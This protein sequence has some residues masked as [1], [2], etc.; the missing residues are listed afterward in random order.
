MKRYLFRII[1]IVLCLCLLCTGAFAQEETADTALEL[2]FPKEALLSSLY[3]ADITAIRQAID[4]KLITCEELTAYYLARIEAYDEDY[5]CF[6]TICDN[7]LEVARERDAQLAEGTAEGMLFGIPVVIKDNMNLEG[8]YTTNGRKKSDSSIAESDA[9][10]VSRLLEEGAVVLA[11]ANMSTDAQDAR[12][13]YSKAAGETKNAYN[14]TLASGGSSGGSA[15]AT[16]LNF[17][18]ASLGTDTNS[19]LR[20]PA[21]LNGCV[22]L[23]P[24]FGLIPMDGIKKL[25][26]SRDMPGAITR[27]VY[28]LAI[29]MDV[30]TNHEYSYT[31]NLNDNALDG[32]RIGV[33]KQLVREEEADEEVL[34]AFERATEE[35]R[36]CGAEVVSVSMSNLFSLAKKTLESNKKELKENLYEE[37]LE[38][39]EEN[40][41]DA[42]VF[43]T[44]SSAPLRSG[45]DEN[46]KYWNAWEQYFLNNCRT[47]GP[48]ASVPEATVIIGYHSLGAGIGM[49]I[50]AARNSEQLLLDIAYTY[51]QRYDHREVPEGAPDSYADYDEGTLPE[52]IDAYLLSLIPPEP[53]YEPEELE[54]P[55][56]NEEP[57]D[58]TENTETQMQPVEDTV[59][60]PEWLCLT[61][62]GAVV[63]IFVFVLARGKR[64]RKSAATKN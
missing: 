57:V 25:N 7:A 40:E 31:E 26:S 1:S 30:L 23:R 18:V 63:L 50:A 55:A 32:L 3:E 19:S 15:A 36:E 35:L 64:K 17:T 62:A 14:R 34:A 45:T 41:L 4:Q 28:D 6:I 43:P 59:E 12:I 47:L 61:I 42:V 60:L 21:A 44:Y 54:V 8:F 22:T 37:F 48:S 46:G 56:E 5:N 27:S 20:I 11:K 53:V 39:L 49:E 52:L 9:Y 13:S 58:S 2:P 24:T 38:L 10:V 29:M 51:T 33:L 16:A